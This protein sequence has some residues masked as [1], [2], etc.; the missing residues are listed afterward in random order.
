[1]VD[2]DHCRH[3]PAVGCMSLSFPRLRARLLK[4][5]PDELYISEDVCASIIYESKQA[6][7]RCK[8]VGKHCRMIGL[9]DVSSITLLIIVL[10]FR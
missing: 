1:M 8:E 5:S 6:V 2:P 9:L 10:I 7:G 3:F 4:A